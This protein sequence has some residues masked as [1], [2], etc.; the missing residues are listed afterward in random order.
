[1]K[2]IFL[3]ILLLIFCATSAFGAADPSATAKT[4]ALL[5]YLTSGL[6]GKILSGQMDEAPWDDGSYLSEIA[7]KS[8]YKYPAIMGIMSICTYC[9]AGETGGESVST[10]VARAI[11]H[12]ETN[13]GII[14]LQPFWSN[15]KTGNWGLPALTTAEMTQVVTDDGNALNTAWKSYLDTLATSLATLQTHNIP[16]ILNPF[17]EM[18]N[19]SDRWY[20]VSA[21]N[22]TYFKN[23]W[24]YTFN[25]LHTTKGLHNIL[26][27][28]APDNAS[29]SYEINVR[30]PGSAY[31]DIVGYSF[32]DLD[33]DGT[34]GSDAISKANAMMS[35]FSG[36]PFGFTEL[37]ACH[38]NDWDDPEL[39]PEKPHNPLIA[40]IVT[41]VPSAKFWVTWTE[42]YADS[43]ATDLP[44]MYGTNTAVITR[45]EVAYY[46]TLTHPLSV[47]IS[48]S[49][50]GT[51]TS[52]PAGI[53]CTT[54]TCSHSFTPQQVQ[55]SAAAGGGST[56][57]G[58]S[59]GGCSGI[60][61]CTV[62]MN[63]AVSVTATFVAATGCTLTSDKVWAAAGNSYTDVKACVDVAAAEDTINV[64]AG[65][66]SVTWNSSLYIYKGIKLIGPGAGNLTIKNASTDATSLIYYTPSKTTHSY[67]YAF[68]LSGFTFD[69]NAKRVLTLGSGMTAPFAINNKVRIDHNVF[70][71]TGGEQAGNAIWNWGSLYG[72]VDSNIFRCGSFPI[73]NH[74]G[75][76]KDDWWANSPQNIFV[77][78]TDNYLYVEDNYFDITPVVDVEC[79]VCDGEYSLRY[80]YR[81][82][83]MLLPE[84]AYALFDVHGYQPLTSD[85]AGMD[86]MFGVEVYGNHLI[87]G[88]YTLS[89]VDVRSGAN[90]IFF[91]DATKTGALPYNKA[92][93]G[94]T[95]EPCPPN[96]EKVTHDNYWFNNRINKTGEYWSSW[97]VDTLNCLGRVRPVLGLDVF[98]NNTSP[99]V[100]CG[101]LAARPGTC[102]TGQGYWA[103]NQSCSDLTGYV[104]ASTVVTGGTRDPAVSISGSL[105]KCTATNTWTLYYTPYT[106]PHPLRTEVNPPADQP[107]PTQPTN[108]TA[109]ALSYP[110]INLNWT[111]STDAVG[112]TGYK[113]LRCMGV[114]CTATTQI[115]TSATTSYQDAN[116]LNST[117]YGYRIIAYDAAG[118]NSI[119]SAAA[120]ATTPTADVNIALNKTVTA[121]TEYGVGWTKE[122]AVDGNLATAW[123]TTHVTP[124]WYKVDLGADYD[125]SRVVIKWEYSY[126]SSYTVQYSTDDVTY[127]TA[128]TVIG[129]DGG[130]DTHI[131]L[132][133]VAARYIKID[134][135][136]RGT[137]YGY[138]IYEL[139]VYG[140]A[141]AEPSNYLEFEDGATCTLAGTMTAKAN[142]NASGGYYVSADTTPTSGTA[143]CAFTVATAGTYKI[144]ARVYAADTSSD[145]FNVQV[146]ALGNDIYDL[147][148]GGDPAYLGVWFEDE[149][150]HRGTGT[151]APQYDPYVFSLAAGAHTVVFTGRE[152]GA[153]LDYFR[154]VPVSVTEQYTLT[155]T[156]AGTGTGTVVINGVNC[157]DTCAYNYNAGTP[158]TITGTAGGDSTF[159]GWSG[160]LCTGTDPCTFAMTEARA[161]TGTFTLNP[162]LYTLTITK[163]GDGLGTVTSSP[164]GIDYGATAA[165]D[166]T[167]DEVVTL[168]AVANTGS[169]FTGWSGT[170]GCTGTST[171]AITMGAAKACTATFT[172]DAAP[173]SGTNFTLTYGKSTPGGAKITLVK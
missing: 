35:A 126:A 147:D 41:N 168:T 11:S 31:V 108:L 157:S 135:T 111:A 61:N 73:K 45:D 83:T 130:T 25:Y 169:T 44:A 144:V 38:Y 7:A 171:H 70:I 161:V 20:Y 71:D 6:S 138:A 140:T 23:L 109:T 142:A 13:G 107:P 136:T 120:Y 113:I 154:I 10:M 37:G 163:E 132:P 84:P 30:Y 79:T 172:R 39:C 40:N 91:N 88:N 92:R 128:V 164:T 55:L 82:N 133:T 98:D 131:I 12:A 146:N 150:T 105:Y 129:G 148:P 123:S 65:G 52:N 47:T 124:G 155:Y 9:R 33:R 173:V 159:A 156:K 137:P 60:G 66:G 158:V 69:A 103:T 34:L 56:F 110:T 4:Q 67:N 104:G 1:M 170:G 149:V 8:P 114:D 5:T 100:S 62:T 166:F 81:Y 74:S 117:V 118:N 21:A 162:S 94:S 75:T 116:L 134:C 53:S 46:E 32:Y 50:S 167:E 90:L 95:P 24:I 42:V 86:S 48:G 64:P 139:E 119:A 19:A 14:W 101:T 151:T 115:A 68:R 2:R 80:A 125:I 102:T 89:V 26:W 143:T 49:G 17:T 93:F 22:A 127:T 57:T 153:R 112:V 27:A 3:A 76:G 152:A 59:G 18:P 121:S 97:I 72:V 54:G 145:S 99:G 77:W 16:V 165:F 160:G 15:P 122:R 36:K 63:G 43:H 78:G 29:T 96:L 106:Y 58:W 87:G 141:I 28:Y 85:G 51:V